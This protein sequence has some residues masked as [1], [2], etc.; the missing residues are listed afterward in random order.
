MAHVNLTISSQHTYNAALTH[1]V[2]QCC[3]FSASRY[4]SPYHHHFVMQPAPVVPELAKSNIRVV[5]EAAMVSFVHSVSTTTP[6]SPTAAATALAHIT[7]TVLRRV[8]TSHCQVTM[9]I[10]AVSATPPSPGTSSSS[11]PTAT[12]EPARVIECDTPP[13]T[14]CPRLLFGRIVTAGRHPPLVVITGNRSAVYH[15]VESRTTRANRHYCGLANRLSHLDHVSLPAL[16]ASHA[17][18]RP[19]RVCFPDHHNTIVTA[20]M[21]A[22]ANRPRPPWAPI[23]MM[24]ALTN[25]PHEQPVDHRRRS[26]FCG[27]CKRPLDEAHIHGDADS[28]SD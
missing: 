10:G 19:C 22:F 14:G 3:V 2:Q 21:T 27:A 26:S 25:A 11:A 9:R 23:S 4:P 24:L 16:L 17:A 20:E 12:P 1:P 8:T 18:A 13:P 5:A 15:C 28:M 6:I 7:N